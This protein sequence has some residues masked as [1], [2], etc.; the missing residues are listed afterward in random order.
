MVFFRLPSHK[1]KRENFR[2]REK[3]QHIFILF[4]ILLFKRG[5]SN[6]GFETIRGNCRNQERCVSSESGSSV[7]VCDDGFVRLNDTYC[8]RVSC[9]ENVR[10]DEN[11]ECGEEGECELPN[12]CS[13]SIDC[14]ALGYFYIDEPSVLL[15][16]NSSLFDET[17]HLSCGGELECRND[18]SVETCCRVAN[19]CDKLVSSINCSVSHALWCSHQ[20][21]PYSNVDCQVD[22]YSAPVEDSEPHPKSWVRSRI[23]SPYCTTST[24]SSSLKD[25]L[26]I[27]YTRG[28]SRPCDTTS[29]PDTF[30][31][32]HVDDISHLFSYADETMARYLG[33]QISDWDTSAVT[34]MH[35]AFSESHVDSDISKWN[36]HRVLDMSYM[37]QGTKHQDSDLGSWDI[38]SVTSLRG[39]FD[40]A[41]TFRGRG[42][43]SWNV[44][45]VSDWHDAFRNT[46]AISNCTKRA[47][48]NRFFANRYFF[49]Q[50][51]TDHSDLPG[52]LDK[53]SDDESDATFIHFESSN[54]NVLETKETRV[55]VV[56]HLS[57]VLM[58]ISLDDIRVIGS[59][60]AENVTH[61]NDTLAAFFVR[62]SLH[63]KD[64]SVWIQVV[65]KSDRYA[66]NT[67]TLRYVGTRPSLRILSPSV[68]YGK[69]TKM[70]E[71][72]FSF[73]V[74]KSGI[75]N[76]TASD[77]VSTVSSDIFEN[78]HQSEH[79]ARIYSAVLRLDTNISGARS[80]YVN[81][82]VF[83][84]NYGNENLPSSVFKF[85]VDRKRPTMEIYSPEM[86][87]DLQDDPYLTILQ[88]FEILFKTDDHT[89][90]S[91]NLSDVNRSSTAF[92]VVNLTRI[93]SHSFRAYVVQNISALNLV[94]SIHVGEAS[95][96]DEA[97]HLSEHSNVF[98]WMYV[99]FES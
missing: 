75:K 59:G 56:I 8:E 37:F 46:S 20:C 15:D 63:H 65:S 81:E 84:D 17:G 31:T 38:T 68:G 53:C 14:H 94:H 52:Y 13:D 95:F 36:T 34:S 85:E 90:R 32:S 71:I 19:D 69:R 60:D 99:V 5:I 83:N 55:R 39:A 64:M 58:N 9:H 49:D 30:D 3:M 97:G 82:S 35:R 22:I 61:I 92:D 28:G 98:S 23:L 27:W 7:C 78:F 91:F 74:S 2:E 62:L 77:L 11:E 66:S 50:Y 54:D 57:S 89:I 79:D 6:C 67:L 48:R 1:I 33:N 43:S 96:R 26:S 42:L 21:D 70:R 18:C 4:L 72:P 86:R 73:V 29:S 24:S 47:I 51:G 87:E 12:R 80:V 40:S 45:K 88:T 10:C 16:H 76:F 41:V 44:V 25:R 93:D